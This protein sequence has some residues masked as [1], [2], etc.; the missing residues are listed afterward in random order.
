MVSARVG[1]SALLTAYFHSC[2]LS[3]FA[4]TDVTDASSSSIFGIVD[5][6][7]GSHWH[8]AINQTQ[9]EDWSDVEVKLSGGQVLGHGRLS[10]NNTLSPTDCAAWLQTVADNKMV[11]LQYELMSIPDV[12]LM[13][14]RAT[15]PPSPS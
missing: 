14:A 7:S 12:M 9:W 5:W 1:G 10:K 3:T 8:S 2:F 15:P 11:P 4:S 13:Q 6:G